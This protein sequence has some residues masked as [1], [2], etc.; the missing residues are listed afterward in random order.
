MA[1]S[2]Q[3]RIV[4]LRDGGKLKKVTPAKVTP[5]GATENPPVVPSVIRFRFILILPSIAILPMSVA[6][7]ESL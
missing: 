6:I 3:Y 1:Q 2:E 5:C 7:P 4:P